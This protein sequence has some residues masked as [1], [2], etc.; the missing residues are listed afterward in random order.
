M[1]KLAQSIAFGLLDIRAIKFNFIEPFVWTS[2]LKSPIYCDNRISLSHCE[3][4]TMIKD[5]YVQ[6]I[7]EN[8]PDTQLIAGVATG[9]VA[10][11]ALVADKLNL[12]FVYVREKSK[13]HGLKKLVEGIIEPGQKTVI[14]EDLVSTGGSSLRA[15]K[16]LM[17]EG[18]NVL[19]MTAIFSYEFPETIKIFKANDCKLFTLC[20]FSVLKDV[21]VEKGD[22]TIEEAVQLMQW[23][24]HT[25][26]PS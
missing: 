13:A 14:I 1:N 16:E 24:E 7:R 18:A 26:S 15:M 21:A 11:G 6:I 17:K 12:P 5:A 8:F 2:G 23:H 25:S 19:G 4:R 9:A 10:Q 3:L 20:N 22:I